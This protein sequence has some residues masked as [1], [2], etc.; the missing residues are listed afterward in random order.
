MNEIDFSNG[1]P[2]DLKKIFDQIRENP[3]PDFNHPKTL[4]FYKFT[5]RMVWMMLGQEL[6]CTIDAEKDPLIKISWDFINDGD[7]WVISIRMYSG[8]PEHRRVE[9]YRFL[10]CPIRLRDKYVLAYMDYLAIITYYTRKRIDQKEQNQ[11]ETKD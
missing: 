1:Y 11:P 5:E 3:L 6:L 2:D 8:S 4:E 7:G 10:D 9:M